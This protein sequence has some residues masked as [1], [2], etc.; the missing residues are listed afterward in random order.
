[1]FVVTT[2]TYGAFTDDVRLRQMSLPESL[3]YAALR[4]DDSLWL[5]FHID[6]IDTNIQIIGVYTRYV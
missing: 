5:K 2:H 4:R 1:M 6:Y 3:L